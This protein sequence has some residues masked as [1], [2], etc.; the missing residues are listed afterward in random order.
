MIEPLRK[1]TMTLS[2]LQRRTLKVLR[3]IRKH[4]NT[5]G[6]IAELS[7]QELINDVIEPLISDIQTDR[8]ILGFDSNERGRKRVD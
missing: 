2:Q 5:P 4:L 8:I 6:A 1:R 7:D 3:E